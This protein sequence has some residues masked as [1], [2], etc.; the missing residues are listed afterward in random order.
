MIDEKRPPE[1]FHN[2]DFKSSL[3]K[4]CSA[5]NDQ[6]NLRPNIILRSILE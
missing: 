6:N 3:Q 2:Y 1:L 4:R 5:M